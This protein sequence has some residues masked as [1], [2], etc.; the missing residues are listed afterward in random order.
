MAA[1][2][3]KKTEAES[4]A[5]GAATTKHTK[6]AAKKP[7]ASSAKAAPKSNHKLVVVESPAK[8]KTIG[9]FL[10]K[11]YTVVA[12]NGHVRDLP[13]SQLG[14][15]IEHDF[16]PKYITLRGR[17]EVLDRIRREAKT[18]KK[19]YLATDPDREGEAISWHLSNVLGLDDGGDY[20][21]VFNEIT[22]NAIKNA[23]KAPRKIDMA[24]VDAQQAR[25]ILDRLVGYKI[26]PLLWAK[27]RKG[28]SAGRVQSVATRILCDRENEIRNFVS[29][30]YWVLLATLLGEKLKKGFDAKLYQKNGRKI[31]VSCEEEAN[32]IESALKNCSYRAIEVKKAEKSRHAP[33][34]FT[35]SN[36]QQEAARKLGF[37][38]KRTMLI[39]Q[40]LYEGVEIKGQG[41]VGLVT[42]IRTD[43]VRVSKEAQQAALDIIRER[44]GEAYAPK[45][46]NIYKG[47]KNAQD[48]HE[49]IRPT[50]PE[51]TPDSV[52]ASLT[53][54]QFKLYRLIYNRF[55]ASQMTPA[56]YET[57]T[58]TLAA[59]KPGLTD[60]Y[61]FRAAGSR[62]LFDG[63][64][65]VYTESR[66]DGG[67]E[68]ETKLPAIDEGDVFACTNFAKE[69]HFTQPPLRYTEA[70]LVR[71]LE[72]KGIG[73]PSTFSPTITTIIE[74]GYVKREKRVLYPTE[75]G[76]IV[77]NLMKENF[78]EIVDVKF[79]AEMEEKLDS[80]EDG[81]SSSTQ[82]LKEFYT[83]F[84]QLLEKAE[85][86]IEKVS[87]ADEVSDVPC[88][89]CGAMMVYKYSRYGRFLACP[90][91][92]NCRNT[93]PIVEP[94]DV[95]CPKCG[96]K[97]LK[98]HSRKSN[99]PFYGCERYPECD[100]VCWDAPT[101]EKC[102]KCGGMMVAKKSRGGTELRCLDCSYTM[103]QEKEPAPGAGSETKE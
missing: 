24:L 39:A 79:T 76:E 80:I 29:E 91:F 96:A 83:P 64:S 11:G 78:A 3:T 32:A 14:V 69:Q 31:A 46:P 23:I 55:F 16:E 5:K 73:R 15:D 42:Y 37:T 82:V 97:L 30:E 102:P 17:G 7:A 9:K 77:T 67:E 98:R 6:A 88:E 85:Q 81:K 47:R 21:I 8:A 62:L 63:Y 19:I 36:L 33:A 93:K 20:R 26:S 87:L 59:E 2:S 66:D 1:N 54:D 100:F 103:R 27:V 34:P 95:P 92:P 89:K 84:E 51:R 72:E 61:T 101:K 22:P 99:K 43:S 52:K 74:R 45:T 68:K 53:P 48:A 60:Q 70:S 25:R 58:V 38:T 35:T 44:Y 4:G 65:A 28:L 94:V 12:S 71:E 40:Q 10:G 49:A 56:Q 90:N 18:A 13:K 86:N 57:I 41:A 75:L 50:Y